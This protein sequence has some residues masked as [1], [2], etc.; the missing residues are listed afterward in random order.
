M[1]YYEWLENGTM[2]RSI[3]Y[4]ND[5][6]DSKSYLRYPINLWIPNEINEML[7][8]YS[9]L[10]KQE[11]KFQFSL[12]LNFYPCKLLK[13]SD[14]ELDKIKE[15]LTYA[16]AF[17]IHTRVRFSTIEVKNNIWKHNPAYYNEY[18]SRFS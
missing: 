16:N 5:I 6:H 14:K 2:Y 8:N 12:W 11:N 13:W 9:L 4:K 10:V 18:F 7:N 3:V 15:D 17:L 1:W